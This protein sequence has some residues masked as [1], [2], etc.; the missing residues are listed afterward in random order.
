WK[1]FHELEGMGWLESA[2]LPKMVSV[3][4]DGCAPIVKAFRDGQEVSEFWENAHT[5]ATGLCVPRSFADRLILQYLRESHGTA[6]SVS[7]DE[8][9]EARQKLA[10]KEGIFACPEGAA[11]LAGLEKLL[12]LGVV[13]QDESVVLFNTGSGLKYIC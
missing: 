5:I 9:I 13:H 11:T 10:Q 7:D 2:K 4:A 3:Q 6:V 1:A 8:I 12:H